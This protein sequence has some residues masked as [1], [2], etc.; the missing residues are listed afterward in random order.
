[1]ETE[2]TELNAATASRPTHP[3]PLTFAWLYQRVQGYLI[4]SQ[5]G[6]PT[7]L[8][9]RSFWFGIGM[10]GI[11]LGAAALQHWIQPV[12]AFWIALVC[13]V[14]EVVGLAV[15]VV[16]TLKREL[17]QFSRPRET[18]AA[19]MDLEFDIWQGAVADLKRFPTPEREA[20]LRF[21]TALRNSMND[22]MGLLFGGIQRLGIFPVLVALYLQFRDWK[23]GDWAGAFDVNLVAGFFILL[24]LLLYAGGWLLVGLRIRL[25]T[26]VNLLED[27]LQ[28]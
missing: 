4:E 17:P 28:E 3:S 13:V 27:S 5:R 20:R 6:T 18:H 24:M 9:R 10:A 14:A 22:R 19:E 25:D 23:W 8:E 26:Y 7:K 15:S 11:G 12:V 2:G 16:L 1:M 21:A